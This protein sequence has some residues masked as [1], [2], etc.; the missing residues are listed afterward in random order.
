MVLLWMSVFACGDDSKK[1]PNESQTEYC[2]PQETA[3]TVTL[4][5]NVG[6]LNTD[7]EG[8]PTGVE[9]VGVAGAN[10]WSCVNDVRTTSNEDGS[11]ILEVPDQEFIVFH[12]SKEGY[13][14]AR[15]VASPWIDGLQPTMGESYANTILTQDFVTQIFGEV[16]V[17]WSAEKTLVVVDVVNPDQQNPE[18][19]WDLLGA[20]VEVTNP[21][22][23]S[24]VMDDD[25][26]QLMEGN[27]LS[28]HSDVIIVNVDPGPFEVVV[29]PPDGSTCHYPEYLTAK[30]GELLHVSIYCYDE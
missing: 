26:R 23:A 2:L 20:V 21:F 15:W 7:Q 5:G 29:T 17:Q 8:L 28:Y 22:G 13:L 3:N 30:A 4:Y 9:A 14:P 16:G 11:F 10:V 27:E 1:E 19:G 18:G 12:V 25:S 6:D 24:L